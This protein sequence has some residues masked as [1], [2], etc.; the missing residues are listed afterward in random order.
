MEALDF[1]KLCITDKEADTAVKC[2]DSSGFKI[3]LLQASIQKVPYLD[4]LLFGSFARLSCTSDQV[5]ILPDC[6]QINY[7]EPII[8]FVET[9]DPLYLLSKLRKQDSLEKLLE[10]LDFLGLSI[11]QVSLEVIDHNLKHNYSAGGRR[12]GRNAAVNFCIGLFLGHF[13]ITELKVRQKI[14]NLSLFIQSHSRT[15]KERCRLHLWK[16][17]QE[18]CGWFTAKQWASFAPWVHLVDPANDTTDISDSE[19]ETDY[20]AEDKYF[21]SDSD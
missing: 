15:F 18:R 4:T 8:K 9:D 12:I 6:I 13:S 19:T 17:M 21:D 10:S 2:V 20:S 1:A 14:Y 11:P 5:T 7:L 3:T 16:L